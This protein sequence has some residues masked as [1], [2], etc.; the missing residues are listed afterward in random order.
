M[1]KLRYNIILA[2]LA[3]FVSSCEKTDQKNSYC[4]LFSIAFEGQYSEPVFDRDESKITFRIF[5]DNLEEVIIS[6]LVISDGATSS[7]PIGGSLNFDNADNSATLIITSESGINTKIYTI[8]LDNLAPDFIG[9]WKMATKTNS[10]NF[11][12][13]YCDAG[14]CSLEKPFD[15][16][17][18]TNGA[19]AMD[20]TIS[21]RLD[22]FNEEDN[23]MH[24]QYT[25][26][27]GAD[28]EM[29][30]YEYNHATTSD[31]YD[32]NAN[33]G[34]LFT[35]GS[36]ELN[37]ITNRIT[38][39][40]ADMSS[41]LSTYTDYLERKHWIINTGT[42]SIEEILT[43]WLP[44]NRAGLLSAQQAWDNYGSDDPELA[45]IMGGFAIEF[46]MVR[47]E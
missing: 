41:T 2:V 15:P 27:P 26:G 29:G 30:S 1:K 25:Y 14:D 17:A 37:V 9:D 5:T 18:F 38:F 12:V 10:Y 42:E 3:L 20:N 32:F 31:I 44:V 47:E 4:E 11:I 21:F 43:F 36:W 7:S 39:S 45:Y 28:G 13:K 19:A 8:Y 35:T 46:N 24:G 22:G 33:Y 34:V 16:S 6:N 23:L 40:N